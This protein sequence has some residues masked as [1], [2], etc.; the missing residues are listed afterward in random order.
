MKIPQSDSLST[1][2]MNRIFDS[3]TATYKFYWFLS[4][5]DMHIQGASEMKAL[6]VCARMVAY[7][8]YPIEYFR[9]SFGV[10]D[11]MSGIIPRVAEL[12]GITVDDRL[13]DK[14][15]VIAR[16][17]EQNAGV[18]RAVKILLQNV[19]YRFQKPWIDTPDNMEMKRRS[20]SLENDC[21]YSLSGQGE[22]LTVT[23]NPRW[24]QYLITNYE[25]LRSFTLWHLARFIQQKNPNVPNVAGK[26]IRPEQREPLTR[27]K[28]FWN[29]VI[30]IGGAVRC[31]YTGKELMNV[32]NLLKP[33]GTAYY[34]VRRD[35][36]REGFRMHAIHRQYTYQC[37]VKLPFRS[38]VANSS[39]ELYQYTP[40]NQLPREEGERCPFCKLSRRVEII[41]ETATCVAFYDG[42]PVSPGHAL[43]I[44]KRHVA[45]YFD[46]TNHERE[47]INVMLQ[48][49][50]QKV[51]ERFHPDAYNIGINVGNDA[52]QS[53]FHCHVHLIPRYEGDVENPKGGVRGVIPGKQKY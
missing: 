43:I 36:D 21:L 5:L 11:S 40:F 23:I 49:V 39:F 18:R 14:N 45:S 33:K 9:L 7:A 28:H 1:S 41:C 25:I 22:G 16:A 47:A 26:L 46:L 38:M 2:Y 15:E 27:Q 6:D 52:G 8:W 10:G 4:I 30:E 3:T 17:V 13:D 51:D 53:V 29:K 31:I 50:K 19:P 12:T 37:N 24:S 42:Y 34:A 32:S 35:L 20:Q 44:P 48:Y